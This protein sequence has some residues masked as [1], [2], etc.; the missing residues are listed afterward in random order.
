MAETIAEDKVNLDELQVEAQRLV[1]LLEDRQPGLM[2]WHMMYHRTVQ[3]IANLT[4][5]HPEAPKCP[6][7]GSALSADGYCHSM[8]GEHKGAYDYGPS[9]T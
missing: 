3:S 9:L 5:Y 4:G 2:T 8:G 1:K 6:K 7:C